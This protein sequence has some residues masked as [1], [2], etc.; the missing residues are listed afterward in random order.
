MKEDLMNKPE[1][2]FQRRKLRNHS[3]PA[4]AT[5]WKLLKGSQVCGLKFRRQ[6]GVGP[7][8]VD[9]YCPQIKLAIE[10]DG[11]PHT[12]REDYDERRTAYLNR[13]AGITVLRYENRTVFDDFQR[14]ADEIEMQYQIYMNRHETSLH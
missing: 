2:L 14:I 9:F 5:L 10:L 1:Q 11:D 8:I 6:H 4:E 12:L 3:T 13:E 7:Y